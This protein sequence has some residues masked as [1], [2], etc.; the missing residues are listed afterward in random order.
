MLLAST[1]VMCAN[2]PSHVVHAHVCVWVP[3]R[4]LCATGVDRCP[5]TRG[6]VIEKYFG[7]TANTTVNINASWLVQYTDSPLCSFSCPYSGVGSGTTVACV[8]ENR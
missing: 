3:A 8:R 5:D 1:A 2:D 4:T 6:C 7:F